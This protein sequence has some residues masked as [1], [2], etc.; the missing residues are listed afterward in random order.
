[1]APGHTRFIPLVDRLHAV[2]PRAAPEVGWQERLGLSFL[3]FLRKLQSSLE[4]GNLQ[5]FWLSGINIL[6]DIDHGLLDNMAM[7]LARILNSR[8]EMNKVLLASRTYCPSN[9]P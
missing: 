2:H 3:G 4:N 8:A 7:R 1:M 6:E 5:H 9:S